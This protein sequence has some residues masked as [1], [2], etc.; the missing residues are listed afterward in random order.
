MPE[1]SIIM[2]VY[3]VE[4]YI[5]RAMESVQAQTFTDYEFLIVDDGS[6]DASGAIAEAYAAKD[7]RIRLIRQENAGAP[8]ARN[9]ALEKARGKYVCFMDS[10]DWA[11]PDMLRDMHALAEKHG[12]E[13]VVA[14]FYIDT[15]AQNGQCMTEK[16]SPPDQVFTSQRQFRESAYRLFD[17]NLLYTPWNKLF[18]RSYLMEHKVVFPDTFWDD[19]PFNLRVLRDVEKVGTLSGAYYHFI[20]A[21]AD[22]ETARY[23]SGMYEKR[24]EEHEWMLELYRH[25]QVTDENSMEMVHRRYIERLIGCVENVANPACELPLREKLHR[26]RAMIHGP[27]AARALHLARPRSLMMRL[28][29]LP[30]RMR[31]TLLT[32][33]EGAFIS[34]VKRRNTGVFARLKA[35]R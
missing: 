29:L 16:I 23:R 31:L 24:E 14:G 1:I 7:P 5:A 12:L 18:L 33:A 10:D 30:V 8:A 28:M 26:V 25:W 32:Y 15:F 21:R 20:R 22:S 34:W 13:E 2:P 3:K 6:P 27:H 4:A 11:E 9:K 17:R 19:F 35:R